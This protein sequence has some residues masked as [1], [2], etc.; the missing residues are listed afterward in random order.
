VSRQNVE[1]TRAGYAFLS[2][3]HRPDL[4]GMRGDVVW[5]Q[6]ADLP[7]SRTYHGHDGVAAMTAQWDEAFE[8]FG[9][10]VEELIDAGDWVVAVVQ[11]EGRIRGSGHPVEMTEVHVFR[12]IDGMVAEVHEYR[13]K[14]EALKSVGLEQ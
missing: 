7:D 6:R 13:T 3:T 11:L 10:R 9:A 12:W 1:R 5:H 14:Q 8:D 4:E 2:R